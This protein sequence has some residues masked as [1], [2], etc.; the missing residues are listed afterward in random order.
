M[1]ISYENHRI[2][3]VVNRGTKVIQISLQKPNWAGE[4]FFDY[5]TR[6]FSLAGEVMTSAAR[7]TKK[8]KLSSVNR[9]RPTYRKGTIVSIRRGTAISRLD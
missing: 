2:R 4:D 6:R 9:K 7:G 3:R 1:S 5:E 8:V